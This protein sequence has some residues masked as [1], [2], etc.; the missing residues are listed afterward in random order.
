[1]INENLL[2]ELKRQRLRQWQLANL[3]GVSENTIS[4]IINGRA[5]AS[6]TV[7]HR[8]AKALNSSVQEL[9]YEHHHQAFTAPRPAPAS[10]GRTSKKHSVPRSRKQE[11]RNRRKPGKKFTACYANE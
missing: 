9:F 8:I 10:Q 4:K 5:E 2:L 6:R 7:R 3:A 11:G 1:M